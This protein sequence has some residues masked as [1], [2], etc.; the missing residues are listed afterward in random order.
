MILFIIILKYNN[1]RMAIH[2]FVLMKRQVY[3]V[4]PNRGVLWVI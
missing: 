1:E 4:V 2:N 3:C